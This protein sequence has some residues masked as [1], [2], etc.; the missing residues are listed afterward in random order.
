MSRASKRAP[1][2]AQEWADRA[3]RYY[4]NAL[5]TLRRAPNDG[6][7]YSD[8]KPV[9][10]ACGTAYLAVGAALASWLVGQG[11]SAKRLPRSYEAIS[12]ALARYAARNGKVQRAYA[13]AYA[14]LHVAGYYGGLE[15]VEPIRA[16]MECARLL[17]ERLTGRRVPAP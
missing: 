15:F 7:E 4:G 10:E 6:I 8:V 3:V 11:W 2:S 17:I 13:D 12:A 9:Q 1:R 14:V 5:E 16:G